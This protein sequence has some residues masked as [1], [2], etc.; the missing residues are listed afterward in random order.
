MHR[1][2]FV[3]WI[4]LIKNCKFNYLTVYLISINN[5]EYAEVLKTAKNGENKHNEH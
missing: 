2:L 5:K 1:Y 4:D 3:L